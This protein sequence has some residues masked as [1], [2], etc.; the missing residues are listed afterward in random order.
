MAKNIQVGDLVLTHKNRFKKVINVIPSKD[1]GDIYKLKVGTRMTNLFITGN[2]VVLTNLGWVRVDELDVNKHLIAVNGDLEYDSREYTIDLKSYTDYKFIVEN[3]LIKKAT[4]N[5]KDTGKTSVDYYAKVNEN[6]EVDEDLAW[7][8]GVWFAEGSLTINNKKEPNGIRITLNDNDELHIA[9][10]WLGIVKS[11][12]NVNGSIYITEVERNG[13]LN[14]WVNV[15]INS[16]IIGNLF[17]SFGEGCKN[18]KTLK[19]VTNNNK[20]I[21]QKYNTCNETE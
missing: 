21:L 18:K 9:K 19:M 1:K 8:L 2:H 11:K 14:S 17:K 10:K 6:I 3:G 16:K 15:N 20:N 5:S 13:K 4:E 12:F 7:A